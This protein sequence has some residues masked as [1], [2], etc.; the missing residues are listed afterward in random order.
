MLKHNDELVPGPCGHSILYQWLKKLL[1]VQEAIRSN[2]ETPEFMSEF[3]I[4]TL[5]ELNEIRR[6][7]IT[8]KYEIEDLVPKI[9]EEITER[10]SLFNLL[11]NRNHMVKLS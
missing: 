11:I 3:E 8:E 9:Y 1:S 4:I 10:V 6:I 5:D 2:P 7:W